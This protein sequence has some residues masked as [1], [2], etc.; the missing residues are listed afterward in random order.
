MSSARDKNMAKKAAAEAEKEAKLLEEEER[1]NAV[2]WSKGA[3]D[4]SKTALADAERDRK[5]KIKLENAA[6]FIF[7]KKLL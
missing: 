1:R 3:K 7:K 5:L 4:T 2:E 6:V